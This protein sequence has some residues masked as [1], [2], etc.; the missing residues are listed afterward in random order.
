MQQVSDTK[1][2]LDWCRAALDALGDAREE[3][4]A[5]NVFPVADSDTG[6]NLYLTF[7][8]SVAATTDA[9]SSV[10]HLLA[11][12]ARGAFLGARGNS[13]TILAQLLRGFADA[14][15]ADS[16]DPLDGRTFAEGLRR[17]VDAAYSAV[18]DPVEGTMLTVAREAAEAAQTRVRA[19]RQALVAV[20]RDAAAAARRSLEKTPGQL[21]V[22]QRA[23]VVD[24]G[25]MGVV[26]L[27]DAMESVLTGRVLR[28]EL[29][30]PGSVPSIPLVERTPSTITENTS[31]EYEVMYLLDASDNRIGDLRATLQRLGD[32]VVIAGGTGEWNVHVHVDDVGAA[33]EAGLALGAVRKISVSHLAPT[34]DQARTDHQQHRTQRRIVAVASGAGIAGLYRDA[35]ATVL[36]FDA[37]Q[38]PSG[39][40]V[41]AALR[42]GVAAD[43]IIVLPNERD[44]LPIAEAAAAEVRADDGIRIAVI[45][46]VAQVQGMAALAVHEPARA[47][48]TEV[49]AMTAAAGHT[50]HGAVTIAETEGMTSAGV[51]Q[52]GD[53]LGVVDGDF[54]LIGSDQVDVAVEVVGRMLAAGGELVTI[55]T[56]ADHEAKEMAHAV[57]ARIRR[58][59]PLVDVVSYDGGQPRYPLLLGVE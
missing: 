7:E 33:I 14:I 8:E 32:S 48:D 49:V 47:F 58:D 59:H 55:V 11:A 43:E 20:V 10:N 41:A 22:L 19:G 39:V 12:M 36:R 17:G 50:R 4:D 34:A 57:I 31:P 54:A 51:C 46:T 45:P 56:G 52:A 1:V 35:G 42:A 16:V 15:G 3:I 18:G 6:T 28:H 21:E 44:L 23:G 13:G 37:G 27:L 9:E 30:T 2:V 29:R 5:V 26:I 24:A 25:G 53:V 38:R 40:D